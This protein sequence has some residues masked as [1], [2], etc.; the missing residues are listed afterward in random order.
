MFKEKRHHRTP[1]KNL[2]NDCNNKNKKI[3]V[4]TLDEITLFVFI[5]DT[6]LL[7]L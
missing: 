1:L 6:L 3:V 5:F 2:K 4:E 7:T